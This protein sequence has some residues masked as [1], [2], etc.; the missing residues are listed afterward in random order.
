LQNCKIFYT[1]ENYS[2]H[3][4]IPSVPLEDV[5]LVLELLN[6]LSAYDRVSP[7]SSS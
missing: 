4:L 7:L 6:S 1:R 5:Q 3:Y 2:S